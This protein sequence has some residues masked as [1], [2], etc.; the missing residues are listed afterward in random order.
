MTA[1]H[2]SWTLNEV[3]AIMLD[4][5]ECC[6]SPLLQLRLMSP[7][8]FGER[9]RGIIASDVGDRYRENIFSLAFWVSCIRQYDK[10]TLCREKSTYTNTEDSRNIE[11]I[12]ETSLDTKT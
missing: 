9:L 11:A 8:D 12:V 1:S 5:V 10:R 6:A 3:D 7:G 4:D 2:R